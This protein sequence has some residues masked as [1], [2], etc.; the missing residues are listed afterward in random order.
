MTTRL[1]TVR[2]YVIERFFELLTA[3][4]QFAGLTEPAE[5]F[6][7]DG[8]F[9][10][11]AT[12]AGF[13]RIPTVA[14]LRSRIDATTDPE[15]K[16]QLRRFLDVLQDTL[17]SLFGL[18]GY[19]T[20]D[21]T[22]SV[23]RVAA[24]CAPVVRHPDRQ[25]YWPVDIARYLGFDDGV[26]R[27]RLHGP[28]G[29]RAIGADAFQVL[30]DNPDVWQASADR[31]APE[32]G[33][34]PFVATIGIDSGVRPYPDSPL[35]AG[36]LNLSASD[37]RLT[38]GRLA[39]TLFCEV[40]SPEAASRANRHYNTTAARGGRFAELRHN[41]VHADPTRDVLFPRNGGEPLLFVYHAFYPADDGARRLTD[42]S[43]NNRE[44]HHLAI[45]LLMSRFPD[46]GS[47]E[48]LE[49]RTSDRLSGL[50]FVS[51]SP[52]T[53]KAVPL[54]HP[55]LRFVDDA[56]RPSPDGLHP[57]L[58]ANQLAVQGLGVS[59]TQIDT[60]QIAEGG[61]DA[62]DYDP[63]D[64]EWWVGLGSAAAVG[65]LIGSP[66]GPVGAAIG[67]AV[68]VLVFL[69]AW[70]LKKLFGGDRD[71]EQ[72]WTE[73]EPWPGD[74]ATGTEY[75]KPASQDIGP[76]GVVSQTGGATPGRTYTL[77]NI[78]HFTG[79]NLYGLAFSGADTFRIIDDAARRE[80]LAWRAF[81]GGVGYQFTRPAPGRSDVSGTSLRNYFELF[82]AKYQE[83]SAAR[84]QVV[85]F[86]TA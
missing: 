22:Q 65:A 30:F 33:R 6:A 32:G 81:E 28:S 16:E 53:A 3:N 44:F 8:R 39:P 19:D 73:Q 63:E 17:Y 49:G 41:R 52:T 84:D 4:P 61:K 69:L 85:Y 31:D 86:G 64:W 40:K 71:R 2:A 58:Y 74:K 15:K 83:L 68:A 35:T 50:L 36:R 29:T 27:G 67:A 21:L 43:G 10:V 12:P 34:I 66:A 42:G 62:I 76:P 13:V 14:A 72:E 75:Q 48:G 1:D 11:P 59:S 37:A 23:L 47:G 57:V 18:L 9:D 45:G 78:P 7:Q 77:R 51:T 70:L 60:Q 79:E 24:R 26:L 55:Q 20:G 25:T 46:G 80:T 38:P 5:L 82:T 56:G 54:S